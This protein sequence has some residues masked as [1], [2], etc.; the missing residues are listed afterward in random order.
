MPEQ[1]GE[2]EPEPSVAALVL[3]GILM[4]IAAFISASIIILAYAPLGR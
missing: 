1:N 3:R 4:L 2:E